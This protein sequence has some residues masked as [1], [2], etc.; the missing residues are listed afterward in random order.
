MTVV[1]TRVIQ[2]IAV[3]ML[4]NVIDVQFVFS[5]ILTTPSLYHESVNLYD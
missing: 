1:V 4:R 3:E 2:N 5:P